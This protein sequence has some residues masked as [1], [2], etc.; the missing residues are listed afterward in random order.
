MAEQ[1]LSL[2]PNEFEFSEHV[3]NASS[4][5]HYLDYWQDLIENNQRELNANP[6]I[7]H[8]LEATQRRLKRLD[9]VITDQEPGRCYANEAILWYHSLGSLND[10][11]GAE[12]SL[13]QAGYAVEQYSHRPESKPKHKLIAA[14]LYHEAALL[15]P[16]KDRDSIIELT[17]NLYSEILDSNQSNRHIQELASRYYFDLKFQQIHDR[18]STEERSTGQL[19]WSHASKRDFDLLVAE[20][21]EYFYKN[22][23][24]DAERYRRET[25]RMN[26]LRG[27]RR[28]EQRNLLNGMRGT[29]AGHAYEW[30]AVLGCRYWQTKNEKYYSGTVRF[31]FPREQEPHF[32]YYT[33]DR[34]KESGDAYPIKPK[35]SIDAVMQRYAG[36]EPI[37]AERW[38]LKTNCTKDGEYLGEIVP[39]EA[40]VNGSRKGLPFMSKR[41]EYDDFDKFI[42]LMGEA[43]RIFAL[44]CRGEKPSREESQIAK[45][46]L[47]YARP[48]RAA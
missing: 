25:D 15:L 32:A 5:D 42:G 43:A 29:V 23:G 11:K 19:G 3:E 41:F 40:R 16:V 18:A 17:M 1:I 34:K 28:R 35:H 44:E 12:H 26:K 6:D 48:P 7:R 21:A 20:Q 46:A 2:L 33:K 22:L 38:Q 27:K 39:F 4:G 10:L 24:Q 30:F 8:T 47:R 14:N 13:L 45:E 36:F 9:K 37:G 31:S